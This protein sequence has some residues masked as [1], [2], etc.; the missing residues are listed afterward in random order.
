MPAVLAKRTYEVPRLDGSTASLTFSLANPDFETEGPWRLARESGA[1]AFGM[2][3]IVGIE[4]AP[5]LPIVWTFI[6]P[7]EIEFGFANIEPHK[8]LTVD[9]QLLLKQHI[10]QF[11]AEAVEPELG[12]LKPVGGKVYRPVDSRAR[13]AVRRRLS[14]V[15]RAARRR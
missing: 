15:P 8:H 9:L 7:D 14:A 13:T 4:G 6:P 1:K 12:G 11:F 2:V 5:E 3:H 10:E